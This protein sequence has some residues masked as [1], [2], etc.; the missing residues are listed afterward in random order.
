MKSR[1]L[2]PVTA[3]VG[4]LAACGAREAP[5]PAREPAAA[6]PAAAVDL[7]APVAPLGEASAS[8]SPEPGEGPSLSPAPSAAALATYP[9]RDECAKLPGFAAFR[10]KL[11]AAAKARDADALAALA[12][13][14]IN[15][16]F[17][18]GAG[19]DELKKRLSDPTVRLWDEIA[20]LSGLGCAVD[21]GIATLPAIFSR[22]PDDV[23]A[24]TTMLI[25]GTEVPLRGKPLRSAGV[26]RTLDWALV[27]LAGGFDPSA[28]YTQVTAADGSRGSISTARLRSLLDYRLIAERQGDQW[29][30]T[31]L[32]AGD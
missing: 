30:I 3:A 18:G 16:D 5:A 17:G 12:D 22:V 32:I 8:P 7:A 21:G 13:P 15:L 2:W 20:A 11:F 4:L 24:A 9:P 26:V 25:T 1:G 23:D 31:A 14:K 19:I 10:D 28:A 6:T 29:R 27:T